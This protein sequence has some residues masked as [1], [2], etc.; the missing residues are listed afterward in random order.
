MLTNL[1]SPVFEFR[2]QRFCERTLR[3]PEFGDIA[4]VLKFLDVRFKV[5]FI[6]DHLAK[7]R[8]DRPKELRLKYEKSNCPFSALIGGPKL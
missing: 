1:R 7:F 8:G 3:L 2:G 4:T 5:I 6:S